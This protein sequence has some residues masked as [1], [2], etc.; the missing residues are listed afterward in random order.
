MRRIIV[1]HAD[2]VSNVSMDTVAQLPPC[3]GVFYPAAP[4]ELRATVHAHLAGAAARGGTPKAI[5]VPHAAY[6]YS[7]AVATAAY[8]LLTHARQAVRR[9]V[10]LG[11]SHF[12]AFAG[13]ATTRVRAFHTPLGPV[14]LDH[15]TIILLLG[16]PRIYA[17]DHILPGEHSLQVQL[18]F[19][20]E[21]LESF[22]VVPL[23]VGT[24]SAAAVGRVL[25]RLWGGAETRIV[26]SSDLSHYRDEETATRMDRATSRLIESVQ[27]VVSDEQACGA[28]AINGLLW[29]A[30][31][32][33]LTVRTVAL[34]TSGN[35]TGAHEQVVGYGAYAVGDA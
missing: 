8:R 20:Q 10:L 7:G 24:A 27:P 1:H 35:A 5:I 18:P 34:G 30:Q 33:R 6:C 3:A 13:L 22:S 12:A 29:A 4:A 21:V 23:A 19:L 25:E 26:V 28:R 16:L 2:L 11:P 31:R 15:D 9:I 17:L 32:R 14:P